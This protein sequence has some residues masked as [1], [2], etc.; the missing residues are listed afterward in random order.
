MGLVRS[1]QTWHTLPL[2]VVAVVQLLF[3]SVRVFQGDV[4]GAASDGI[5]AVF[6]LAAVNGL[7]VFLSFLYGIAC[8]I[9]IL[10]YSS[11]SLHVLHTNYGIKLPEQAVLA[12]ELL[13]HMLPLTP[14]FAAL[15]VVLA[16]SSIGTPSTPEQATELLVRNELAIRGHRGPLAAPHAA[17]AS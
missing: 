4:L 13:R 14:L 8:A 7:T 12:A 11:G 15:G 1:A 2:I 9:E 6:G 10:C 16:M 17:L 5:A 3:C